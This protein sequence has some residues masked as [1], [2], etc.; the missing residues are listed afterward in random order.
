[1]G[2]AIAAFK[3]NAER[4]PDSPNVRDSLGD[5]YCASRYFEVDASPYD[6]LDERA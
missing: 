3:N 2:Q 1:M 6:D 5:A 4:F